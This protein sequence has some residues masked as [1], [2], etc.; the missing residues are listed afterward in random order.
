M[1]HVYFSMFQCFHVSMSQCFQVSIFPCLNLHVSMFKSQTEN[2]TK[3]NGN[4]HLLL[5]T[6]NENGKLPFVCC[7]RK[8]KTEVCFVWPSYDKRLSTIAVPVN[9]PIFAEL[10]RL[11][12]VKKIMLPN[13]R[14]NVV[15]C[16][17]QAGGTRLCS[18][19]G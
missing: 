3:E 15:F 17:S 19:C 7:K 16:C 8:R 2:G 18:G 14:M 9:L 5:Q 13:P 4:F 1:S 6:E 12:A 10:H 11:Q